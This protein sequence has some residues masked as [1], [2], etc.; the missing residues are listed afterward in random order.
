MSYVG[1]FVSVNGHK[2]NYKIIISCKIALQIISRKLLIYHYRTPKCSPV[3]H[4]LWLVIGQVLVMSVSWLKW[5][6]GPRHPDSSLQVF[7]LDCTTSRTTVN[8]SVSLSW[9]MVVWMWTGPCISQYIASA[10]IAIHTTIYRG[11]CSLYLLPWSRFWGW[12]FS[13]DKSSDG[14]AYANQ[15]SIA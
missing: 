15:L 2:I 12:T 9:L 13:R 14:P 6:T 3:K 4:H 10:Y 1:K 5:A 11:L 8:K 7:S